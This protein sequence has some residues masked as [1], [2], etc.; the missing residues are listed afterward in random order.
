MRKIEK[1]ADCVVFALVTLAASVMVASTF[2]QV[3]F[4]YLVRSPLYWSEEL[5]RYCFVYLVFVGGAWAGKNASHLGVDYLVSKLP[6]RFS[7]FIDIVIDLLVMAFSV[8]VMAVSMRVV[9]VN[10]RQLSPALEIPM[11]LVYLAIP[12]GFALM[13][14]YYLCHL[15]RHWKIF[16]GEDPGGPAENREGATC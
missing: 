14:V 8:V 13:F 6:A 12:V 2:L 11:G 5:G 16:K 15:A 4:R 10:M 9:P 7:R 1:I 3:F